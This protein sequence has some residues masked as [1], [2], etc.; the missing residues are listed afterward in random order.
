MMEMVNKTKIEKCLTCGTEIEVDI[1][2]EE[3]DALICNDCWG[4][5]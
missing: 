1:D 5:D 3:H 2:E 4:D